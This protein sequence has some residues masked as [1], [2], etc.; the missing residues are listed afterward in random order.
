[1]D[2][3]AYKVNEISILENAIKDL[4]KEMDIIIHNEAEWSMKKANIKNEIQ[5]KKE[6]LDQEYFKLKELFITEKKND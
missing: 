4:G 6:T 2:K 5:I 1:M 3:V